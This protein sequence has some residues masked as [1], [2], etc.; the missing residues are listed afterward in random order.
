[1]YARRDVAAVI[2]RIAR[3]QTFAI[4]EP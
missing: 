3:R 2:D 4:R 1:M